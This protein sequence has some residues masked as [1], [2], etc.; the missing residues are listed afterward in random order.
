MT[1][2]PRVANAALDRMRAGELALGLVVRLARSGEIA[3]IAKAS[4]HDFIFVDTQHALYSLETIGHIA[5]AAMGAGIA[6]IVRVPNAHDPDIGKLL[7]AGVSGLVISDVSTPEEARKVVDA[8]RFPPIG[9]RSVQ[10]TYS[11]TRYEQHPI[12]ELLPAIENATLIA[13]MIETGTALD[14]LEAIAAVPGIDVLHLGATDLLAD[15]GLAGQFDHPALADAM[16]RLLET[17]HRTGKFAGL[18]GERDV[19]RLRGHIDRGLRF[20]TTQT[21][22]SYLIAAA[23]QRASLIRGRA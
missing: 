2:T 1:N 21:D 9:R 17:C 22:I 15:L 6:C 18:G 19:Q 5:Q 13:C 14:N 8:C 16:T 11:V 20:H 4:G 3:S 23:S 12:T 10:S 7:D